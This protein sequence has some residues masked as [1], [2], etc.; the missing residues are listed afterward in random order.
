V[1]RLVATV[2]GQSGQP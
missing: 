2:R 1:T